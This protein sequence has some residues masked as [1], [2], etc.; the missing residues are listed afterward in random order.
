[1]IGVNIFFALM[2]VL[3]YLSPQF[4][5]GRFWWP[6]LLGLAYPYFVLVN[7]LLIVFWAIASWKYLF[8][9][10]LAIGAGFNLH[11]N[12]FKFS[13]IEAELEQ[14]IKV[15]SYNVNHFYSYLEKKGKGENILDFIAAQKADII[16]LQ[17]T[18]LKKTGVLS[19]FNLKEMF[20]GINHL[21][22]AHQSS[23]NGP[24]TFSRFPIIN[25]GELRFEGSN[26]MVIF[27]DIKMKGDTVRV[28]NCHL[29]SYG[30]RPEDYSMID[31]MS[32]HNINIDEMR[33]LGGKLK[34]GY[35]LRSVQVG[36]L[37]KHIDECRHPVIVCGDFNDTP[38][39]F[40]Y[41]KIVAGLADAFVESGKGVSNTYRGKLP[42]YRI[43]YIMHSPVFK[44]YN[45]KRHR[46]NYSDHYPISSDLVI[47][48]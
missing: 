30:I 19:P 31:S 37:K 8:I 46:V 10:L 40:T 29:Q 13:G 15:L 42:S 32:F 5:P 38:I 48:K 24:V 7:V 33:A 6:S 28:Y 44:S 4:D 36:I 20:P 26:N 25:M 18:N 14:P 3:S 11:S 47:G 27:T 16:C 2:L 23:W 41:Q 17:E 45:Y 21:Q 1:M 35:K 9:S 22:L 34:H 12:F 39:S 43:D